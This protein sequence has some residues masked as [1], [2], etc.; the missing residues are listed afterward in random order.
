MFRNNKIRRSN[1][2]RK[3]RIRTIESLEPRQMMAA[4]I[5]ENIPLAPYPTVDAEAVSLVSDQARDVLTDFT[6]NIRPYY[7]S[8]SVDVSLD[9]NTGVLSILGS[10]ATDNVRVSRTSGQVIVSVSSSYDG[11]TTTFKQIF[12][13]AK[14]A[15][16]LFNGNAGDDHFKNETTLPVVANGGE[17]DDTL[18][19]GSAADKLQGGQGDDR[20]LGGR[21]NDRLTCQGCDQCVCGGCESSCCH[22]GDTYCSEC[23]FACA[24]CDDNY[25][26]NCL[27]SC[28]ECHNHFCA[29]CLQQD[30]R[31]NNCHEKDE[32]S[33][34]TTDPLEVQSHRLG[35]TVV[36][37]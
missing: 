7:G 4:D 3:N 14:V 23:S 15:S 36:P 33:A 37:A 12:D 21:G 31:C 27:K 16:I 29:S 28:R 32:P 34:T 1:I 20:L 35:Q 26:S 30:E 13:A 17:G 18:I 5:G 25:C 19:G 9:A 2:S 8:D 22:C 6:Y 11:K 24:G 10:N